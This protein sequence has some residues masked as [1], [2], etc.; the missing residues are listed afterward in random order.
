[1]AR[2]IHLNILLLFLLA[3]LTTAAQTYSTHPIQVL[4]T[5]RLL[6]P[7]PGK[8][9]DWF[10]WSVA[11]SGRYAAVSA[12]GEKG[13]A[14]TNLVQATSG[15]VYLYEH[16]NTGWRLQQQLIPK[17]SGNY[18]NLGYCLAMSK[19]VIAIAGQIRDEKHTRV[20]YIFRRNVL[21]NEWKEEQRLSLGPDHF[22]DS[23]GSS[24]SLNGDYLL[25]GARF[26]HLR[27]DSAKYISNGGAAYLYHHVTDGWVMQQRLLHPNPAVSKFFGGVLS[28]ADGYAMIGNAHETYTRGRELPFTYSGG[29]FVYELHGEK[30]EKV[31]HIINPEPREF[32]LF[33]ASVSTDGHWAIIGTVGK[34]DTA[35]DVR[36]NGVRMGYLYER[37][38]HLWRL[39]QKL[40]TE[41]LMYHHTEGRVVGLMGRHAIAGAYMDSDMRGS[42]YLL[43]KGKAHKWAVSKY[44][45]ARAEPKDL[46]GISVD[47]SSDCAIMGAYNKNGEAGTAYI[48]PLQAKMKRR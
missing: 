45:M 44:V 29:V 26:E 25:V 30:L 22:D 24:L 48:L 16:E 6:P 4:E 47:I 27:I 19:D 3:S 23:F 37:R 32:G 35:R 33:G 11:L 7:A 8:A 20:V 5:S 17:E 43:D 34:P 39:H 42:I 41:G 10:G 13:T 1:M 9:K 15:T 40:V 46:F 28:I 31:Q 2:L 18:E 38:G 21:D 12:I 14:P 36:P